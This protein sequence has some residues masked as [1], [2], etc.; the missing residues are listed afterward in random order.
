M[1]Q[2]SSGYF[3]VPEFAVLVL[4]LEFQKVGDVEERIA[5]ESDIDKCRLHAGQ[6]AGHASFI[7]GTRQRV[8]VFALEVHF[9]ALIVFHPFAATTAS[10]TTQ[11]TGTVEQGAVSTTI[12][13]S[14][15]IA[16][17]QEVQASFGASGTIATVNVALG[18][19]VTAGEVLGTLQTADLSTAVTNAKTNLSHDNTIL[20]EDRTAL[21][22]AAA[23][24]GQS[25]VQAQQQ[26]FSQESTV[27]SAQTTLT[28][29][30]EALANATLTSPIAGL[31]VA[32]NGPVGE[33]VSGGSSS[34]SS[35]SRG[36]G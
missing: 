17:V 36:T 22:Q 18:A 23:S 13:A 11:L 10:A 5:F 12:T 26:V 7:D 4:V 33:T 3:H 27:A 9:G 21:A 25:V 32:V 14:G 31:V 20:A 30:E 2:S 28:S 8:L 34:S 16:P 19:T 15:T 29:A 6:H 24:P 35:G 1:R